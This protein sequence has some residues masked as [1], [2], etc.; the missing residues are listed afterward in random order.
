MYIGVYLCLTGI[1]YWAGA[2]WL[3]RRRLRPRG[4]AAGAWAAS[5]IMLVLFEILSIWAGLVPYRGAG[6]FSYPGDYLAFGFAGWLIML[7]LP[8]GFLAPLLIAA[9]SARRA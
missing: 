1:F 2:W 3:T 6:S 4:Y 7:L 9:W 5:L 8:A